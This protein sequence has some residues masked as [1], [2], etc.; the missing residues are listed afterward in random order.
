MSGV[1]DPT[2]PAAEYDFFMML[3]ERLGA[4]AGT[5]DNQAMFDVAAAC[6]PPDAETGAGRNSFAGGRLHRRVVAPTVAS[7]RPA[8][9]RIRRRALPSPV[10]TSS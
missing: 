3:A 2:V 8:P 9:V 1:V 7:D 4:D 5:P 10:R 6:S